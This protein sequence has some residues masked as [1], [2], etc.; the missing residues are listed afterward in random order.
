MHLTLS[1]A[2]WRQFCIGLNVLNWTSLWL[3]A[4]HSGNI[5]WGVIISTNTY[6]H[7]LS[8]FPKRNPLCLKTIYRAHLNTYVLIIFLCNICMLTLNVCISVELI[9]HGSLNDYVYDMYLRDRYST[10]TTTYVFIKSICSNSRNITPKV[11]TINVKFLF[12]PDT[13]LPKIYFFPVVYRIKEAVINKKCYIISYNFRQDMIIN[14]FS[15]F[16]DDV[17]KF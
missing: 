13:H 10:K 11:Y 5:E 12:F 6:P 14:P 2:K 8:R 17:T 16:S 9:Y 7:K 4:Y 15:I 1:P 3:A